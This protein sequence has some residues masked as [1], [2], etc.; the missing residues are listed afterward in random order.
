M[1]YWTTSVCKFFLTSTSP[2]CMIVSDSIRQ[3]FLTEKYI[4]EMNRE[5]K[6]LDGELKINKEKFSEWLR[7]AEID[8]TQFAREIEVD[9]GNFSKMINGI[10]PTPKHVIEKV[11]SRTLLPVNSILIFEVVSNG[12]K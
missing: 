8:Q 9:Y 10:I 2:R 12:E 4:V 6:M 3:F 5:A 7:L 11:L 1:M